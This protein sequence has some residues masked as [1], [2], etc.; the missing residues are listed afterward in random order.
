MLK[1]NH[2][3]VPIGGNLIATLETQT[4]FFNRPLGVF[5][6]EITITTLSYIYR[7]EKNV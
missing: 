2:P 1:G 5:C 4:I 3:K 7:Y 6:F